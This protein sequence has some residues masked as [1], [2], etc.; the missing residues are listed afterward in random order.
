LDI[1]DANESSVNSIHCTDHAPSLCWLKT[2]WLFAILADQ[3][4][5]T[6]TVTLILHMKAP[7][8][9]CIDHG[10]VRQEHLLGIMLPGSA[11]VAKGLWRDQPR[12]TTGD[13][14]ADEAR[15]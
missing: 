9:R 3:G 5:A 14:G 10:G 13:L 1:A 4:S 11:K 12:M 15:S 7:Y 2:S 6:G 8:V